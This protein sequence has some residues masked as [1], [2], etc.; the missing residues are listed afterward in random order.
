MCLYRTASVTIFAEVT[1][2][3]AILAVVTC[4]APIWAVSILPSTKCSESTESSAI[5][6][7]STAS[8]PSLAVVTAPAATFAVVT[9][10]APK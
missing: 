7:P 10:K 9:C 4:K 5:F 3:A 1:L 8:A 2:L 6:V